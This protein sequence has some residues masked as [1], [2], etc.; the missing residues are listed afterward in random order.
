M[1][2][3]ALVK[4]DELLEEAVETFRTLE[5]ALRAKG[6]S[7]EVGDL[8][9]EAYDATSWMVTRRRLRKPRALSGCM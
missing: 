5:K 6:V 1:S 3:L 9:D 7:D 4:N 2:L 8:L